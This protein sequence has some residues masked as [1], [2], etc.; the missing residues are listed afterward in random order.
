MKVFEYYDW[1]F[2]G[3]NAMMANVL[4]AGVHSD[5]GIH[6][7]VGVHNT[8]D[9]GVQ[10]LTDYFRICIELVN[11]KLTKEQ[12][13]CFKTRMWKR[14]YKHLSIGLQVVLDDSTPHMITFLD[15][16]GFVDEEDERFSYN[17]I[18]RISTIPDSPKYSKD[19][20]HVGM[21]LRLINKRF[22]G[23]V[24][25]V[26]AVHKKTFDAV[27]GKYKFPGLEYSSIDRILSDDDTVAVLKWNDKTAKLYIDTTAEQG[28]Y[29]KKGYHYHVENIPK[30]DGVL[31]GVVDTSKHGDSLIKYITTEQIVE[32]LVDQI[33]Y[34]FE[35]NAAY[36]LDGE[37]AKPLHDIEKVVKRSYKKQ[38]KLVI[39]DLFEDHDLVITYKDGLPNVVDSTDKG[40][41]FLQFQRVG[42]K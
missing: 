1:L 33:K 41:V 27:N 8:L 13:E 39:S 5:A 3:E 14:G 36:S 17:R 32:K 40:T 18:H 21:K 42:D 7:D 29:E 23:N 35:K 16:N 28:K 31:F 9:V 4:D 10:S 19:N 24:Y 6:L 37:D 11:E 25:T 2:F 26:T 22:T 15:K 30:E 38:K 20:I 12:M 34:A